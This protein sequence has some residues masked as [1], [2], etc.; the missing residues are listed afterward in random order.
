MNKPDLTSY[1]SFLLREGRRNSTVYRHLNLLGK[2]FS[3]IEEFNSEELENFLNRHKL[4]D[5]RHS[6][7]NQFID[8]F[9]SYNR[10]MGVTQSKVKRFKD[11]SFTKATM[12]DEE[13]EIF[14]NLPVPTS[15]QRH[16]ITKKPFI[17]RCMPQEWWD[18]WTLFWKIMAFSG[19]RT[20]EVAH[21]TTQNVDW[22]RN[23]FVLEETKT[24]P[25]LVPIAPNIKED[26]EK[27]LVK[28]T[29]YLFPARKKGKKS[30]SREG[31]V[32]DNVDWNY[33]FNTRTKQMGIKRKNL[34]PYSLRH[35][36]ISRLLSEDVNL[37][38]V[39]KLV[40]HRRVETT[41]KY[42]HLSTKD[43]QDA[44][45][46]DPMIRRSINPRAILI[47]LIERVTTLFE[48]DDRFE[49]IVEDRGDEVIIRI[50]IKDLHKDV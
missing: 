13:I 3:E 21:L 5:K 17:R 6:Y 12:S 47:T 49:K 48:K 1:K 44:I 26:L 37:F 23:V 43:I 33:N 4:E 30:F 29:H 11:Q 31:Q 50:K 32:Y 22:G 16:A 10:F 14:L 8:V 36:L 25:R 24:D 42:V 46:K 41:A 20:T 35:S 19:M 39:Q 9:Y 7:L 34:T 27:H 45:R 18:D 28:C 38:K 15:T 2:L 40:G